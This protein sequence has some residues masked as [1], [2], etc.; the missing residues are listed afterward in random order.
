MKKEKL[1]LTI[2][3]LFFL[4]YSL[5]W[6]NVIA[7]RAKPIPA[8]SDR[9]IH[10]MLKVKSYFQTLEESLARLRQSPRYSRNAGDDRPQEQTTGQVQ[11]SGTG[12]FN[13]SGVFVF[14]NVYEAEVFVL[15]F[16][17]IV[18]FEFFCCLTYLLSGLSLLR[19][20]PSGRLIVNLALCFDVILKI[21]ILLFYNTIIIPLQMVVDH[22]I[23][24]HH[25]S[26]P[27]GNWEFLSYSLSGVCLTRSFSMV[28]VS[29]LAVYLLGSFWF[30]NRIE[31]QE[32]F[33][34]L[35]KKK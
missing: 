7:H 9:S 23:L 21:S 20:Y 10:L 1:G 2:Y 34:N 13:L 33:N 12:F 27:Q 19:P 31:I 18:F 28:Y 4:I 22:N 6:L 32:Y 29:G 15:W 30:F 8:R 16:I 26:A 24:W 11:D 25:F 17:S 5:L 35:K 14:L 3:G